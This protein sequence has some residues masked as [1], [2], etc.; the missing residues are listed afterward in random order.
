MMVDDGLDKD[1][2]RIEVH[3]KGKCHLIVNDIQKAANLYPT[4]D[5]WQTYQKNRR[6]RDNQ[7]RG[8]V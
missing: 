2:D 6:K 1:W 4:G 3:V 5:G 8:C 7:A